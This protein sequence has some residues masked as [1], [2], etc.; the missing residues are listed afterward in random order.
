MSQ[1]QTRASALVIALTIVLNACAVGCSGGSGGHGGGAPNPSAPAAPTCQALPIDPTNTP[2]GKALVR[3]ARTWGG[4]VPLDT[5]NVSLRRGADGTM[6]LVVHDSSVEL[7]Q[8]EKKLGADDSEWVVVNGVYL[9]EAY[10]ACEGTFSPVAFGL[11][12]TIRDV[13]L[14]KDQVWVATFDKVVSYE[15]AKEAG[16]VVIT[17]PVVAKTA[18][19]APPEPEPEDDLAAAVERQ[20]LLD[21]MTAGGP[22]APPP[23]SQDEPPAVQTP[24]AP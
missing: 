3:D 9:T 23:S 1:I 17:F 8:I 21:E 12:G 19:V 4:E 24:P 10:A 18:K 11:K 7:T 16:L 15:A 14:T 13:V 6:A 5:G 22:E 2:K 20:R